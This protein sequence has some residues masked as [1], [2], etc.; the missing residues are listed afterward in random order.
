MDRH[1]LD[2]NHPYIYRTRDGGRHWSLIT[3]G[4]PADES[5]NVVREDPIRRGLLYAGTERRVYVSFDDGARWQLLQLNLPAASMRD[6]VFNGTDVILATH[7][8]GIWILDDASPLR[9]ITEPVARSSAHLFAPAVAY[10]TR[11]GSD[12]GTPVPLDETAMPNPP[13]GAILDYYIRSA[14]TP[15]VLEVIDGSGRVVRRWSS[16]DKP[17]AVNARALD[18]PAFWVVPAQ[19]PSDAAGAHRFVWNFEYA[20]HVLAPPGRYTIRMNVSGRTYSQPL[21]LRRDPTYPASD[22]DLRAQFELA[23]GIDAQVT[24]VTAALKRAKALL[25]THPQLRRVIGEAPPTSQD[26]SVGKPA[27]DFGSL[28]YLGDALQNLLQGVES[29]DVRPTPDQYTA[30]ALLKA[31]AGRALA[32]V[33]TVK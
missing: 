19:P 25:K 4:I 21:V 26:D 29:A 30:F 28:R 20:N 9:Q 8:R 7:G 32:E 33:N 24:S 31:K 22:A 2:D 3:A 18:I 23:Q 13:T 1:R 11:P 10:R 16:S 27:Q 5:V 6:I 15:L 17:Q 12:Q 14:T